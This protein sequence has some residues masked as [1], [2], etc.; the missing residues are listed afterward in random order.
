MTGV[1]GTAA[2]ATAD[3]LRPRDLPYLLTAAALFGLSIAVARFETPSIWPPI[4]EL[5]R[6]HP[7]F[8]EIWRGISDLARGPALVAILVVSCVWLLDVRRRSLLVLLALTSGVLSSILKHAVGRTRPLA[9]EG[10]LS[11]P[12]GHATSAIA[13]ALA[14]TVSSRMT[15][16]RKLGLWATCSALAISR[17][18]LQ[19]H[20]PSDVLAGAA[21][22]SLSVPVACR[23][24]VIPLRLPRAPDSI[25]ALAFA[26][27]TMVWIG[28]SLDPDGMPNPRAW[29]AMAMLALGLT[30]TREIEEQR[31]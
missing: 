16:A 3:P 10:G 15:P 29:A 8:G 7:V 26:G 17:V 9:L 11:W 23:L 21:V 4:V 19:R 25:A 5:G 22:A 18:M 13:F 24:P 1:R 27:L 12:S 2:H 6:D 20:W 31:E 14:L 30:A 28:A